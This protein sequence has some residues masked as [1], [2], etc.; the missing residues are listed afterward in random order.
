MTNDGSSPPAENRASDLKLTDGSRVA[1]I[2]G[3]PAGS[4]F[5]YFLFAGLERTGTSVDVDIYESRDFGRPGPGSCNMC[6]GIISESLV[7][8][9]AAEGILLPP[10]VV[11]RGIDSYVMHVDGGHERIDTSLHEKRIAAV[12]RGTGPRGIQ[13]IKWGS[14]DGFLLGL[15]EGAGATPIRERV[16]EL[17]WN[18]GRPEVVTREGASRTYD[19]LVVATGV[20]SATER[21]CKELDLGYSPPPTTKTY[22]SEFFLGQQV[23]SEQLGTSMHVFLLDIPR[24]EFAALIPKG[25]YVTLVLLGHGIDEEL[26][27]R[28]LAHPEVQLCLPP[29]W[30]VPKQFCHCSPGI[31][32]GIAG[33]YFGD[34]VVFVGD[35]GVTRLYKDGIGAA[36]RAAKAAAGTVVFEGISAGDFRRRYAPACRRM[37]RDNAL[38]RIVFGVT[39]LLR[40]FGFLR[41]GIL[42]MVSREQQQA[43]VP[44]RMSTVLWDT[45]TGS[46]SYRNILRRTLHPSFLSRFLWNIALAF[47]PSSKSAPL[48]EK[49][50][51]MGDLGKSYQDGEFIVREGEAGDHMYVIQAGQVEVIRKDGD[52]EIRLAVLGEGD[53]FGEMAIFEREVRS[54]SVRALG[55]TRVLTVDKKTFL[56]RINEDP[57]LAFRIV[58]TLSRRIRRLDDELIRAKNR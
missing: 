8:S 35:C 40:K 32:M 37:A 55:G 22:I 29:D 3:G 14:F 36:Y 48:E 21:I 1:V 31:S 45:F 49:T 12:H 26:V 54:A 28:F 39:G 9:L 20:N 53:F 16:T 5:S 56:G 10:T 11:Q 18:D 44:G 46:A 38:G 7:Q 23:V 50:M 2:G 19:L 6:G 25:D 15:A 42:L 41:R 30:H 51:A 13:E 34:R 27:E 47:G 57:S 33:K 24:L 17:R 4:F 52:G 58:Q 43:Q